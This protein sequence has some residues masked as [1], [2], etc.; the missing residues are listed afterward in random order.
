[1]NCN[2]ADQNYSDNHYIKVQIKIDFKS[3]F[4]SPL[5][6][7]QKQLQMPCMRFS[8]PLSHCL[9]FFKKY[10]NLQYAIQLAVCVILIVFLGMPVIYIST[11]Y[12]SGIEKFPFQKSFLN[13]EYQDWF[14]MHIPG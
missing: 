14:E 3:Y 12:L 1:M 7:L 8:T 13:L 10:V 2:Q 11:V 6:K 4:L 9:L 5:W